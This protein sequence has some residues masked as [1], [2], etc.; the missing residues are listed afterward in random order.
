LLCNRTRTLAAETIRKVAEHCTTEP[1]E[2]YC[3]VLVESVVLDCK[4]GIRHLSGHI[5][6]FNELS[7]LALVQCGDEIVILIIYT[8]RYRVFQLLF[9][10]SRGLGCIIG[11]EE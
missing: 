10:E 8:R 4:Y 11:K 9:T 5:F 7:L 2:V 6:Y 3:P 1:D